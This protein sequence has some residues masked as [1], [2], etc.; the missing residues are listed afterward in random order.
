MATKIGPA[1]QHL[2]LHD[3][4][5]ATDCCLCRAEAKIRELEDRVKKLEQKKLCSK[6]KMAE[7]NQLKCV[8]EA[9]HSGDCCWV[10]DFE[11]QRKREP[12]TTLD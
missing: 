4:Y 1:N 9:G 11:W 2:I 8:S 7:F 5:G 10:V 3:W 12:Y 6:T